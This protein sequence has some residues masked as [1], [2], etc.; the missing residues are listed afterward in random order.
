[1][2][3]FADHWGADSVNGEAIRP[4][5]PFAERVDSLE[6]LVFR[7]GPWR[8]DVRQCIID[9]EPGSP[10]IYMEDLPGSDE[11]VAASVFLLDFVKTSSLR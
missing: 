5:I 11:K 6:R 2:A 3:A 4:A 10:G 1:M 8:S 9:G 7:T